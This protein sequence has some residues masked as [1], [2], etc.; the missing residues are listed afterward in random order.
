LAEDWL[1]EEEEEFQ[2][3]CGN[4]LMK[5]PSKKCT[6]QSRQISPSSTRNPWHETRQ[7]KTIF[8]MEDTTATHQAPNHPVSSR[9]HNQS[10]D[11]IEIPQNKKE[12]RATEPVA[13]KRHSVRW[14]GRQRLVMNVKP[15]WTR[16][17]SSG[18]KKE[19]LKLHGG[20]GFN[21]LLTLNRP[22]ET[23]TFHNDSMTTNHK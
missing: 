2:L 19:L 17:D 15:N 8:T 20:N 11:R 22:M 13:K 1:E 9:S 18:D 3:Y 14:N 16:S 6:S 23:V 21:S 12:E 10:Q 7:D 5:R 4:D